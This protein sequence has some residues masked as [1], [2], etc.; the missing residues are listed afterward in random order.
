MHKIQCV[1]LPRSG[2]NLLVSHLQK[3]FASHRICVPN[4][5]R[6]RSIFGRNLA[7]LEQ[8]SLVGDA[9]FHYCE[10]Y[11]SCR[12]HP[13]D[14]PGNKFQKSHDFDLSLPVLSQQKYVVQFRKPLG[15]LISWFEM[16]LPRKREVDSPD[17]F[18]AFVNRN[19]A[20]VDGFRKKWIE[21]HLPNRLLVDY[22]EYLRDPTHWLG[23]VV[24]C[25]V[26]DQAVEVDR[27][28][29]IVK[30]VR[31]P[32]DNSQFRYFEAVSDLKL[33]HPLMEL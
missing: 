19:S 22:D 11:Y 29:D 24:R 17:G 6:N 16:R 3:Y 25:F 2:H 10:Y 15:L 8:D 32:K 9:E 27:I 30:D 4:P 1:S 21:S 14:N 31:P 23:Q 13:C 26:E 7:K 28:H 5:R 20:Y 33:D 18:I 12:Q